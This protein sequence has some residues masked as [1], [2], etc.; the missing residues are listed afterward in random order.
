MRIDFAAV[1]IEGVEAMLEE[2]S[3]ALTAALE[4]SV[5]KGALMVERTAK[6]LVPVDTGELR[7]SIVV[8]DVQASGATASAK[9]EATAE[10]SV[11]VE[12]GTG[13]RGASATFPEGMS[14]APAYT[15]DCAGQAAQPYMYPAYAQKKKAVIKVIE[16]AVK[17]AVGG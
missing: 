13:A 10:H 15:T 7:D 2:A 8:T 1:G 12:Y 16:D 3:D 9:V 11:Y 6:R 5:L 14:G 17:K 4:D